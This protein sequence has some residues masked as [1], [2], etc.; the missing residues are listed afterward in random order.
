MSNTAAAL[1]SIDEQGLLYNNPFGQQP[2]IDAVYT[3][4]SVSSVRRNCCKAI[5]IGSSV[6]FITL[7]AAYGL[8]T[9][10][11]HLVYNTSII[12]LG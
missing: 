1:N 10:G 2:N 11:N 9:F 3:P 12:P 8:Y 6:I 4:G 5:C 7:S